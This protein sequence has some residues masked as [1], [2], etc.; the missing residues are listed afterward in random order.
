MT[1]TKT[2]NPTTLPEPGGPVT[3]TVVV[4][5]TSAVDS[6]TVT[7]LGDERAR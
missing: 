1:V 2:A 4:R 5:N 7:S 3:F 6:I